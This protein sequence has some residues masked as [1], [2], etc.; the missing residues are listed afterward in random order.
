MT[1]RVENYRTKG[2]SRVYRLAMELFPG[3]WGYA[4]LTIAGGQTALIDAGSGFGSS[5]DHL[6]EALA[7]LRREFHEAVGWDCLTH[8]LITHGHIDH[9]GG[10]P[11]VRE[12]CSAA[13]GVHELDLR[14]LTDYENR[15]TVVARRLDRFL[16]EAGVSPEQ[17]HDLMSLYLLNKQLFRSVDVDLVLQGHEGTVG[18]LRWLHVPGHCPG[19]VI[20]RLDEIL[21][22]GDHLLPEISPH[23]SP[24]RLSHHT[25]LGHYLESLDRTSRWAGDVSLAL[26]GH[27]GPI[28]DV[29]SR[30]E[31]IRRMHAGRLARVLELLEVPRT[32]A[33]VADLLFPGAG[34]YHA[35]LALQEA[36]AHV[37]YLEQRGHLVIDNLDE[38]CRGA[39]G[40]IRYR[41][42]AAAM[43][44]PALLL[45]SE[46]E[47]ASP[48]I[49]PSK[50]V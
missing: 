21:L 40:P 37:E 33:E 41:R 14:V 48:E 19:H 30:V 44:P 27:Q 24:E 32:V 16:L 12:R 6:E 8:I 17:R 43:P 29:P 1:A 5:N 22:V 18:P 3:F 15:L 49:D 50:P 11:Y 10:L 26:G 28:R 45:H 39:A 38:F 46:T 2:G 34:G 20:F 13:L 4:H 7:A 31:A 9:F 42:R 25:G 35:L 47:V 23:Q 36:G